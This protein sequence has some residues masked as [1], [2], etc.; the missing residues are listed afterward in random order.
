MPNLESQI[1]KHNRK[2]LKTD[3]QDQPEAR[4][5]CQ[6]NMRASC[7]ILG[8]CTTPSVVYRG[9]ARR[10]D[11][12]AVDCYTGL[13][14]DK[15]KTRYNKHQSDIRTGKNTASKLSSHVCRLKERNIQHDI[16]WGI[17]EKAPQFNP[18]TKLCRLCLTEAY[19]IIFT[20][21]GANLNKR[22]E[23]SGFCKHKWKS[24]LAKETV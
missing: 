16:T 9:T 22:D 4:C 15:F 20:S 2:L 11:T 10:H 13:T 3:D 14:S 8:K 1:D 24:L 23:L 12:C 21:G 19:H 18:T 7:P 6:V 5:N 17:I